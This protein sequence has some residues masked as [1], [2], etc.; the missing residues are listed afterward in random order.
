REMFRVFNMG[1][2]YVLIVAR[3]FADSI[4]DKL[5][6]AGEQVWRIGKVTGGTGKVILK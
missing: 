3:D 1:I 2:G 4:E 6:R 5:R